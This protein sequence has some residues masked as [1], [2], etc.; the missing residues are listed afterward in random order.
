MTTRQP[1]SD[2]HLSKQGRD[3]LAEREGM[4][5]TAYQDSVGVWTI[6]LGHTSAAG[7]P[8]VIEGMTITESEAWFIFGVDSQSFR[9]DCIGMIIVPL[10]QYEFDAIA[11]FVY[12]IGSTQFSTSTFL[13]RLNQEDYAGAAEA[14]L[15]WDK[16]PEIVSRRRGEYVEFTKAEYVARVSDEEWEDVS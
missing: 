13:E 3:V 11:S 7:P 8:E 16:P 4:E 14:M 9:E 15:W 2:L 12:N 1:I 10:Y 5:L 6:G